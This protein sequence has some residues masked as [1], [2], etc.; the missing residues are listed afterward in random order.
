MKNVKR[1]L[2]ILLLIIF[3]T[4]V[5]A[6]PKA[7]YDQNGEVISVNGNYHSLNSTFNWLLTNP[8]AQDGSNFMERWEKSKVLDFYGWQLEHTTWNEYRKAWENNPKLADQM[9]KE[10]PILFYLSNANKRIFREVRHTNVK[11]G[12][13][14]WQ[15][16]DMGYIIKTKDQT[17]AI[18]VL[19][20]DSKELVDVI[21]YG[22][23]SHIHGDHYDPAFVEAMADAGK[24][25]YAPFEAYGITTISEDTTIMLG[26]AE[27][28]FTMNIQGNVPVIVSEINLG[29]SANNYT[30][31]DMADARDLTKLKPTQPIDLMMLHIANGYDP[32][33]ASTIV[34]PK[35]TAY[36]HQMEM[37]HSTAPNGWRWKYDY[38]YNKIQGQPHHASYVL[39]W[40]ERI[41]V[42]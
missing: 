39:T 15:L 32:I 21:D 12:A 11:S 28:K 20:R 3:V 16:Y 4:P 35:A 24:P 13:V 40:G 6:A 14:I 30:V 18:D 26:E 2:I 25:V 37:G 29:E 27:A 1:L 19:L 41:V 31:Y 38:T 10:H 5:Q 9:E 36:S 23:V 33:E 34:N 7:Q 42:K 8:P 17:I 22:I